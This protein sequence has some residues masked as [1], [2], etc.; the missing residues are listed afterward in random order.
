MRRRSFVKTSGLGMTALST[1]RIL[2]AN[3]R[4]NIALI[5]CGGRGRGVARSMREAPN[6]ASAFRENRRN[7]PARLH[8]TDA[9]HSRL[10]PD[11]RRTAHNAARPNK[12]PVE[13][14]RPR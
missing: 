4:V 12:R 6:V 8:R 13:L 11:E 10:E 1:Q 9:L 7:H 14:L 5:G 2:G 3:D